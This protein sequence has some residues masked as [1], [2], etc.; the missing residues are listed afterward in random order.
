M[1]VLKNHI[2]AKML[3]QDHVVTLF[4]LRFSFNKIAKWLVQVTSSTN[5][6]IIV[7]VKYFLKEFFKGIKFR[8]RGVVI[9]KNC[10]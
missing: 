5:Q 1:I 2:E 10:L 9:P 4:S 7:E 8:G 6:D 3:A